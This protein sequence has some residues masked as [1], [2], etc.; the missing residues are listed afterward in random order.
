MCVCCPLSLSL[1]HELALELLGG[2]RDGNVLARVKVL[3]APVASSHGLLRNIRAR[4]SIVGKQGCNTGERAAVGALD[5][6]V[7]AGR[8]QLAVALVVVPDPVQDHVVACGGI[9][10]D[11]D[12]QGERAGGLGGCETILELVLD[13][14]W[15]CTE[16]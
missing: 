3:L 16:R 2:H 7:G 6:D 10:G 15:F 13:D 9:G 5:D 12:G 8:V 1:V 4:G 11:L 14:L